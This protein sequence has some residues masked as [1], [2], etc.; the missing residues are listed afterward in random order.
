MMEVRCVKVGLKSK[1]GGGGGGGITYPPGVLKTLKCGFLLQL[2]PS[3]EEELK[4]KMFLCAAARSHINHLKRQCAA[5][6]KDMCIRFTLDDTTDNKL[7]P[8]S[9]CSY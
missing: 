1:D 3:Y 5:C 2:E 8:L 9:T 6:Y 7:T 4:L